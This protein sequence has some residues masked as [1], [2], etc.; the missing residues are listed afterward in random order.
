MLVD[1][2]KDNNNNYK[3]SRRWGQVRGEEALV[4]CQFKVGWGQVRGE[5]AQCCQFKAKIN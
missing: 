2:I 3:F 4:C 1:Y 5:E